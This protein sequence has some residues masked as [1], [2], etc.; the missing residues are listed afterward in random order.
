LSRGKIAPIDETYV[1]D[2]LPQPLLAIVHD[3]GLVPQLKKKLAQSVK[4]NVGQ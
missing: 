1:C 4:K 3:G 2:I